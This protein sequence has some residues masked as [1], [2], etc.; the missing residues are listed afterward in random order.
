V[1]LS[2]RRAKV[3]NSCKWSQGVL[4]LL[5]RGQV[6]ELATHLAM[7]TPLQGDG[8]CSH[9]RADENI[10]LHHAGM[11]LEPEMLS[12]AGSFFEALSRGT[13]LHAPLDVS[14][15]VTGEYNE[16]AAKTA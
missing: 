14:D 7:L 11:L 10:L 5:G 3:R 4:I 6:S 8:S 13:T 1:K 15:N 16:N 12:R 9:P 2:E